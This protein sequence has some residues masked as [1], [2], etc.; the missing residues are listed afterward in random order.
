MR[1]AVVYDCLYPHTIGGAER[2]YRG[3]A[4]RLARR[5]EVTYV[6][7]RQWDAGEAP[8]AP[9]GVTVVAVSAGREL[10]ADSGRRKITT[11]LRFGWGLFWHLLRHRARYDVVQTCGFPYFSL[12]A[13]RLACAF[14][15]PAVVTDWLEVWTYAYW[16]EYLGPIAGRIGAAVQHLCTR[17]TGPAFVLSSLHA[18]RLVEEGYPGEPILL[19][20]IYADATGSDHPNPRREPLV[21]YAGRHIP[22]KRV[23]TIPAA[24]ALARTRIPELRAVIFGDG[25]ERKRVQ[26]EIERLDLGDVISCPGFVPWPQVDDALRRA[27]C[28][29]LLSRREGYGLVVVEAAARGT[30][31][32]VVRHPDSAATELISPGENGLVAER[33][34]PEELAAAIVAVHAAGPAFLERTHQWFGRHARRLSIDGAIERL[35][36]VYAAVTA[37]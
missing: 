19:P 26:A 1:I 31:T 17:L 15:G 4:E 10:Y 14:G 9:P 22:E 12:L 18:H 2:W 28:A 27:L 24:V 30:P 16:R 6:T 21:V 34:D 29:V 36:D 35:E 25:P 37:R 7:R 11:P 3:V 23:S 13:A 32:I 33:A 5:H 20:G 8:D